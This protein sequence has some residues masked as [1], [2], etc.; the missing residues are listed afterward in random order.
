VVKPYKVISITVSKIL[1]SYNMTV[2]ALHR[3]HARLEN[4]RRIRQARAAGL[5]FGLGV[6]VGI[7]GQLLQLIVQAV[8]LG[9]I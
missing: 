5:W 4:N 8:T 3:M 9:I 6:A 2:N 1:Q 7:L